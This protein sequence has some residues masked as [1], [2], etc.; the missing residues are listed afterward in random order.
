FG[1]QRA[2][3]L[4]LTLRSTYTFTARLTLQAYMQAILE[5]EHYSDV[6]AYPARGA[7]SRIHLGDLRPSPRAVWRTP[8]SEGAPTNPSLVGRWEYLLGSTL[9]LVHTHS[10]TTA[11]TP[12]FG[13]PAGF[14]L[15]HVRPRPAED[16]LL[17]KLSYW[18][19]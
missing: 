4:G 14:E 13:D 10:Q 17:T 9:F 3:S 8:T 2:Q 15:V 5:S 11:V 12:S 19:G 7:G 1:R 6:T 16:A 18:W